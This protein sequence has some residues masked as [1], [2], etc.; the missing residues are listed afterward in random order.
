MQAELIR[1]RLDRIEQYAD[2]AKQAVKPASVPE[3]VRQGVES[4]HEQASEAKRNP[5]MDHVLYR[6]TVLA[7]ED[8]ADEALQACRNAGGAL[9]P[10][11]LHAVQRAHGEL[12]R[13]KEEVLAH[14]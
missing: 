2:E 3:D 9:D 11:V 5:L 4:L 13:M 14:A 12:T 7:L 10:Q 6:E 8:L 1:Q